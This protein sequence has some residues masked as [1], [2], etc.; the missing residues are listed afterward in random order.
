MKF[1]VIVELKPEVLD[2]QGRAICDAINR[3]RTEK[4]KQVR[5]TKRYEIELSTSESQ[6]DTAIAEIAKEF[7]ANPISER[8]E[9]RRL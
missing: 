7:L 1:E 4:I 2:V 3:L 9:V 6:P 8:F 5:L